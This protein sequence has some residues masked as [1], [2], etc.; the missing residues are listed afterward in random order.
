MEDFWPGMYDELRRLARILES[1]FRDAQEVEFTIQ[2]GE[3]WFLE[4]VSLR[5]TSLVVGKVFV[6]VRSDNLLFSGER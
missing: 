6:M 5:R 1:A 2:S 3:L 4:T